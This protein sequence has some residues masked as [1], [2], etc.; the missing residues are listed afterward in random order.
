MLPPERRDVGKQ[1]VG[2]DD[3]LRAQVLD[4]AMEV[5]RIPVNNGGDRQ[6]TDAWIVGA[7]GR[8]RQ[9]GVLVF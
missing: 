1:L 8:D 9:L 7:H 6:R 4:G 2:N 3:A 5:D